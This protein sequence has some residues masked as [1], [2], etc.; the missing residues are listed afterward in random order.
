MTIRKPLAPALV[1]KLNNF[2]EI[3]SSCKKSNRLQL[4]YFVLQCVKEWEIHRNL[5]GM[6]I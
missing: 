3:V 4:N 5:E 1:H 6:L 2:Y